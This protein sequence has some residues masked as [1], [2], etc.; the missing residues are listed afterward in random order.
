VDRSQRQQA[1]LRVFRTGT[2]L[3]FEAGVCS[4]GDEPRW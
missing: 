4:I 3:A 1:D 2:V